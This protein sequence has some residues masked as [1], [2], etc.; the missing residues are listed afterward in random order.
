MSIPYNLDNTD[1]F[2]DMCGCG[3]VSLQKPIEIRNISGNQIIHRPF[4]DHASMLCKNNNVDLLTLLTNIHNNINQNMVNIGNSIPPF[5]NRVNGI[6]NEWSNTNDINYDDLFMVKDKNDFDYNSLVE[7]NSKLLGLDNDMVILQ[8]NIDNPKELKEKVYHMQKGYN[9]YNL[10][11]NKYN[12]QIMDISDN[13]ENKYPYIVLDLST[14]Q[15]PN[16][17]MKSDDEL[18]NKSYENSY[19]KIPDNI[20]DILLNS[21]LASNMIK[22][23]TDYLNSVMGKFKT[24]IN[25]NQNKLLEFKKTI[26]ETNNN[27]NISNIKNF[28]SSLIESSD[29]ENDDENDDENDENINSLVQNINESLSNNEGDRVNIIENNEEDEGE[30]EGGG[31]EGEDEGGDEG[32]DNEIDEDDEID[33]DEIDE[34]D[35]NKNIRLDDDNQYSM[36]FF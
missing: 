26:P 3:N 32:E 23:E 5:K 36:K 24:K 21:V 29:E 22:K 35:V 15:K 30:D 10:L 18:T 31:D 28:I 19:Q 12:D 9:N 34:G 27:L 13:Y 14:K 17:L 8:E 6:I 2:V 16:Y 33:D 11:L 4:L 7:L 25:N 20:S 1:E